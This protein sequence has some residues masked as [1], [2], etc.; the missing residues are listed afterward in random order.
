MNLFLTCTVSFQQ[1]VMTIYEWL[2]VD[3]KLN[4]ICTNVLMIESQSRALTEMT[5]GAG[6]HSDQFGGAFAASLG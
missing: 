6:R 2:Q 4:Q 1:Y 3:I 5:Q